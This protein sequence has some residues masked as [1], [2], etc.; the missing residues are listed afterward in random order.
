MKRANG[1]AIKGG[2]KVPSSGTASKS[3]GPSRASSA[4]GKSI[5]GDA[6][7]AS[8]VKVPKYGGNM[9]TGTALKRGNLSTGTALKH[10]NLSTGT[11]LT[12]NTKGKTKPPAGSAGIGGPVVA[13]NAAPKSVGG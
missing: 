12:G 13:T 8:P 3:V 10:G 1:K 7:N 5:S 4:M 11:A 2:A 6:V 9:S